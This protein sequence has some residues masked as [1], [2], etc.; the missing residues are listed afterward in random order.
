LKKSI[1]LSIIHLKNIHMKIL[2]L[3][4]F[5]AF[6]ALSIC[7]AQAQEL[8]KNGSSY[9]KIESD[10]TVRIN[11]SSVGKFESD[12]TIRANGSSVGKIESDGTIRQNGSSVGKVES[13]GT[14]RINGSSVG[15]IES[16]G[17]IRKNGSSVGSAPGVR[18][19]YAA[20]LFFFNFF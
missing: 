7:N 13:D 2:N 1:S 4:L 12:G 9:A 5:V 6:F 10:G 3:I 11:G 17:T 15:K 18:K 14:V 8:R 19:E 16:D 20:V